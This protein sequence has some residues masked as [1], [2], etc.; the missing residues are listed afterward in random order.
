[1]ADN[2]HPG[3]KINFK[4]GRYCNIISVINLLWRACSHFYDTARQLEKMKPRKDKKGFG[5]NKAT[6]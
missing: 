3:S 6:Y 5:G 1:M 2:H 4:H